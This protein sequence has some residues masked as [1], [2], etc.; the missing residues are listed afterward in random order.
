MGE[1]LPDV[2]QQPKNTTQTPGLMTPAQ[3]EKLKTLCEKEGLFFTET[4]T[5]YG[6]R[7]SK[8][9]ITSVEFEDIY[10]KLMKNIETGDIEMSLIMG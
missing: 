7:Y 4:A 9:R 1:D 3:L 6:V 5:A 8:N 2:E 10:N